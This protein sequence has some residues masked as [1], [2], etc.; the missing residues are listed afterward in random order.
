MAISQRASRRLH[1]E[2]NLAV[3]YTAYPEQKSNSQMQ[4]VYTHGLEDLKKI[5]ALENVDIRTVRKIEVDKRPNLIESEQLRETKRYLKS[6][7]LEFDFHSSK[8]VGLIPFV[9][10][11][12]I[13]VLGLPRRVEAIL[14]SQN[15]TLIKDLLTEDRRSLNEIT[16][17]GFGHLDEL[18]NRLAEH[19]KNH[20]V[21]S[22]TKID[23][24]SWARTLVGDLDPKKAYIALASYQLSDLV[25]LSTAESMEV[26]RLQSETRNNWTKEIASQLKDPLKISQL[27]ADFKRCI[28]MFIVPW[29]DGRLCLGSEDELQERFLAVSTSPAKANKVF[30]WIKAVYFENQFPLASFLPSFDHRLYANRAQVAI[31]VKRVVITAQSYFYKDNLGYSLPLLTKWIAQE[32]AK[33]WIGFEPGFIE[34]VLRNTSHFRVRKGECGNLIVKL[35]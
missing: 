34:K 25:N 12:P 21:D 30:D 1:T 14:M 8:A 27:H 32:C 24:M 31:D 10:R 18:Q 5:Y 35:S 23:F 13:Q 29:L 26:R 17:L 19:L 7:Q 22:V 16:G 15:M 9:L 11:E 2:S 4:N 20:S 6:R 33:H 3:D 28:A